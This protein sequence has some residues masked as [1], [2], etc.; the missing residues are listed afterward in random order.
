MSSITLR[1][2]LA[3]VL[4]FIT[5]WII[6]FMELSNILKS[7]AFLMRYV[8]M[9]SKSVENF[10]AK[11]NYWRHISLLFLYHLSLESSAVFSSGVLHSPHILPLVTNM[12]LY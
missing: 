6:S 11:W 9:G 4:L 7:K 1:N 8:E 12:L 5:H 3:Y 10:N 2:K